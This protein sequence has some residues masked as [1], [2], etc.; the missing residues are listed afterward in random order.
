[1]LSDGKKQRISFARVLLKKCA[2]RPFRRS[3][4]RLILQ[5]FPKK[6]HEFMHGGFAGELA[7]PS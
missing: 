1:M 2:D 4:R 6:F 3:D 5:I 7:Q